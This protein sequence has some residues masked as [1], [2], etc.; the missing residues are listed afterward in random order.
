ML[1][2]A[3]LCVERRVVLIDLMRSEKENIPYDGI[4][5]LKNGSFITSK[6]KSKFVDGF[7][8][9]MVVFTNFELNYQALSLDRWTIIRLQKQDN[10]ETITFTESKI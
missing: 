2:A 10:S 5:A 9:H 6:Y 7:P 3:Q 1:H 8:P 4:E